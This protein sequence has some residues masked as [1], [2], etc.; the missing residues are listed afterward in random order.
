VAF[1]G[2]LRLDVD[3]ALAFGRPAFLGAGF[4]AVTVFRRTLRATFFRVFLVRRAGVFVRFL[5]AAFRRRFVAVARRI[6]AL[7][8]LRRVGAF[9]AAMTTLP[10]PV[11]LCSLNHR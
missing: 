2:A 7:A 1:L 4:L 11:D 3:T 5:T 10:R 8:L 9:L 6:L